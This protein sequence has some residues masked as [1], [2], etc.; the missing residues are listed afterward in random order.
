MN[1]TASRRMTAGGDPLYFMMR[2]PEAVRT[3]V[4]PCETCGGDHGPYYTFA[5]HEGH[6][7][8]GIWSNGDGGGVD[9]DHIEGGP[10]ADTA[11]EV[12]FVKADGT[13]H[14]AEVMEI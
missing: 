9:Y 3:G 8:L 14:V 7:Q 11:T 1:D 2:N 6:P 5:E 10:P 12:V 13:R 4:H